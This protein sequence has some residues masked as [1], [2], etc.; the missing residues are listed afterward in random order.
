MHK[1]FC[2]QNHFLAAL[3]I[4]VVSASVHAQSGQA[5]VESKCITC[6]A[7]TRPENSGIDHLWQR[8]GPDLWYSGS[9]FNQPWLESWLASPTRIR[10]AGEFYRK[11]VK[12]GEEHDVVDES[13][14][15]AHMKLSKSDAKAVASYLMTL[16]APEGMVEAGAFKGAAVNPRMGEMFFKKLRGCG[17]CHAT[18]PDGGGLSAP[19]LYGA[20]DRLQ[21][22]YI[23][24][25]IKNPQ[26]FDS[27]IWMPRLN[28]SEPDLQR[29]TGYILQLHAKEEAE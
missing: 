14:L 20:A 26:S 15:E 17:A 28:L 7:I 16:T 21:P 12:A 11:H 9:K 23:Y 22:D 29:L 2:K 10:P 4:M 3:L 18:E 5:I 13:T 1:K 24:G 19:V 8:R 25:Y 6:H 27:G